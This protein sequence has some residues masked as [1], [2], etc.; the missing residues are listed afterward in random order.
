MNINIHKSRR[1]W[2]GLIVNIVALV[3]M[4]HFI[5][6]LPNTTILAFMFI[7]GAALIGGLWAAAISA[8]F[9][10]VF[11]AATVDD[12]A[13]A[14][15]LVISAFVTGGV[16]GWYRD[17]HQ[18]NKPKIEFVDG[19][20]GNYDRLKHIINLIDDFNDDKLADVRSELADLALLVKGW[21]ALA[22]A[23][24]WVEAQDDAD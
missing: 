24:G 1:F 21:K 13:R 14:V 7:I 6:Y 18:E 22:S 23:R 8:V 3:A 17:R 15:L 19:L 12:I 4:Y 11:V 20:N 5:D 2:A 9:Y 16:L 10:A